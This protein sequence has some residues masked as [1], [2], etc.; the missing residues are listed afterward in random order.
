MLQRMD[1]GPNGDK[2]PVAARKELDAQLKVK[3]WRIGENGVDPYAEAVVE[4]GAP[5]WWDGDEEASSS[6][7]AAQGVNLD[8]G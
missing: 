4:E 3:R 6:F 2:D 1:L 8:G 7:L 5:W